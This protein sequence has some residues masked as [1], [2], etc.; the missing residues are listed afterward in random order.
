M[1]RGDGTPLL[2]ELRGLGQ[3][4][5][6]A[7]GSH[8][9]LKDDLADI[10]TR[11]SLGYE[12]VRKAVYRAGQV[13]CTDPVVAKKLKESGNLQAVQSFVYP[14][15]VAGAALDA[16]VS[17]RVERGLVE[18]YQRRADRLLVDASKLFRDAL[19]LMATRDGFE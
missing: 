3:I 6:N 2:A 13:A 5:A 16:T 7:L 15:G 10:I 18:A 12:T 17:F 8:P 19:W 14:R 11:R 1:P 4:I 9:A